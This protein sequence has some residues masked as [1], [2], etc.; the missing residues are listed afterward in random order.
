MKYVGRIVLFTCL[1]WIQIFQVRADNIANNVVPNFQDDSW[2]YVANGQNICSIS[3]GKDSSKKSLWNWG[4]V[5]IFEKVQR[6]K[7]GEDITLQGQELRLSHGTNAEPVFKSWGNKS[8][9]FRSAALR[10]ETGWV[11]IDP[12]VYMTLVCNAENNYVKSVTITLVV[13]EAGK[14]I[15]KARI[16]IQNTNKPPALSPPQA[17]TE[18]PDI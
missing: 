6:D 15:E 10:T 12:P 4:S 11:V 9:N 5:H 14:N 2:K 3:L 17:P 16:E 1:M 7:M 13:P 18:N 8:E